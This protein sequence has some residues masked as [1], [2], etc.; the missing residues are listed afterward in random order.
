MSEGRLFDRRGFLGGGCALCGLLAAG[1]QTTTAAGPARLNPGE[2]PAAASDEA[3][4]WSAMERAERDIRTSAH[5]VRTP[6]VMEYLT[7]IMT[8]LAGPFARDVRLYVVR[9]PEFNATMAPNGMMQIWTGLLLRCSNEA[10]LAAVIGHE[11]A[12]YTQRHAIERLRAFR[13]G[14][15]I[16]AFLGLGLAVAVGGLGMLATQLATVGGLMAYTRDQEREADAVGIELAAAAGYDPGQGG[17]LWERL[18]GEVARDERGDRGRGGFFAS[19]PA[20]EE[21]MEVI[22]RDTAGRTGETHAERFRSR[23]G[24]LQ[25]ALVE[26]ELRQR[27]Y[28]RSEWLFDHLH[29]DGANPGL[30]LHAL[31][32]VNR[33]RDAAGDGE[34]AAGFYTAAVAATGAPPEAWRGLGLVERRRGRADAASAAFTRYLALKP[35]A[36]DAAMIRSYLS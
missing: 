19:Y 20:I 25:L 4:L 18:L 17:A 23:L 13:S 24:G 10:Q 21:R 35:T 11:L 36:A 31:G 15:D 1:C 5:I 8:Q 12:H 22:R 6:E 30:M 29:K 9:V 2:R 3:S 26:E 28:A 27:R 14:T 32:E 33:L 34:R 16:A 7:G